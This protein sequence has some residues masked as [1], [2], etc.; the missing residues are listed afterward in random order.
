MVQLDQ[1]QA[2]DL[3]WDLEA[4]VVVVGSGAAGYAAA[5]T[6]AAEGAEVLILES[7]DS[8]GGTTA[9]SGGTTWI[10]GNAMMEAA[11]LPDDLDAAVR[12]VA[13]LAYPDQYS[14]ESHNLGLSASDFEL[15]NTFCTTGRKAIEFL[16]S[17]GAVKYQDR[18]R[19]D[20]TPFPPYP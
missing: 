14:S 8:P 15:I 19:P 17:I 16:I 20:G 7:A 10:P 3:D 13:R 18:L 12:Y 6:A 9:K 4:D 5:L 1:E 2:K 11:S